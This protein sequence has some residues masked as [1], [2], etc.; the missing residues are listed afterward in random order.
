MEL[1]HRE[2]LLQRFITLFTQGSVLLDLRERHTGELEPQDEFNPYDIVL[3]VPAVAICCPAA[4]PE[5]ACRFVETNGVRRQ[6]A[7]LSKFANGE[8]SAGHGTDARTS[9]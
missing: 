8:E 6:T 1:E 7:Q 9:S 4:W 2:P 3:L 5:N